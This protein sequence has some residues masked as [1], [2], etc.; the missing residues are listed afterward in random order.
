M[1]TLVI[2][3]KPSVARDIAAALGIKKKTGD[4]FES[5]EYLIAS[6]VGHLVELYMPEDID[7][8]LKSWKIDSLPIIPETFKV[9]P[10]EKTKDVFSGLKKLMLRKDVDA[11][12]NACDAGRE[13]ELIFTYICQAAN[14]KKPVKRLW[15]QS[16]TRKGI[17]EAIEN[18]REGSEMAPLADAARSRSESDWLIGINGTRA[19]TARM[20]GS[21][22]GKAAT[23][24]RVQTPTLALVVERERAIRRFVPRDYWRIRGV[25]DIALGSYEGVLQKVNFKKGEDEHDRVDRLWTEAEALAVVEAVKVG[26][27]ADVTEEKKR[28]RQGAPRLYDLTTLQR[29]ANNRYGMPAGMTLRAAQGLYEKHKLL[30]YPRTDSRCLPEDYLPVC[31]AVMGSLAVSK[32]DESRDDI[33]PHASRALDKGYIRFEKRIFNNAGI[34]DHFAIIPTEASAEGKKLSPDERKIYDM[35]ARRFVATFFP[36]AEFDVT[37]RI[38]TVA[39]HNFR[40]EGKVLA[41][42]GWLD[43]YGRSVGKDELPGLS[44]KDGNPPRAKVSEVESL[45]EQTRPPARYT[46][47]TLLTAMETAGKDLEDEELVEAMKEKG[48]G[49][50]ATRAQ[51]I[52]HLIHEQYMERQSRELIPTGKAESLIDFLNAVDIQSLVS[53]HLT[54]DWEYK[55]KL[56]E[57]GKL[58]RA[59]FMKGICDHAQRVVEKAKS[60]S[61]E[62]QEIKP[63]DI[64][65]PSDGKTMEETVRVFRSQDGTISIYKTIASR[66]LAVDEVR[67]LVTKG[68]VGPLDGFRSKKGRPFSAILRMEEGKVS[69]VFE[70][71]PNSENGEE[72]GESTLDLTQLTVVGINPRD[73]TKVYETPNAFSSESYLKGDRENGIRISRK[74]L[75]K[76]IP[77]EEAVNLFE[78]GETGIIDG[79]ISN[80]TKR[81]FRA[82]L[83]LDV[84]KGGISFKFPPRE[85]KK[86]AVPGAKKAGA[87]KVAAAPADAEAGAE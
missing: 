47:A 51:T 23:V 21:R 79:F 19:V 57:E 44:D 42:P 4:H 53:A 5:D 76:T 70:G 74:I 16:M 67:D 83:V 28:T 65:C 14:C 73:G 8:S 2:A 33:G 31:K 38:S 59:D 7:K 77:T 26:A 84:K 22:R 66:M 86:P 32:D 55:L 27:M 72:N 41:I 35:V 69:F 82:Q 54:G 80:R 87:K 29:E 56:I 60:Y 13:G 37:T 10:I 9:K 48:L 18:I 15:M 68:Q 71:S 45:A 81:A 75:A 58:S 63:T 43:V 12:L 62:N 50:P 30:T 34:S 25:F 64:V 24:G 40:T 46:E 52:D 17:L 61:E 85:P 11:L 36:A 78:K 39:E 49:T 6:A 20:F 3:E 1:K